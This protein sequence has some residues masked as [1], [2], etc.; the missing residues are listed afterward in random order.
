MNEK[1]LFINISTRFQS[2]N[3]KAW[4]E[5]TLL[6][7]SLY[8]YLIVKEKMGGKLRWCVMMWWWRLF[9]T[10]SKCWYNLLFVISKIKRGS[11]WNS[12]FGWIKQWMSEN[13]V[14]VTHKKMFFKKIHYNYIHGLSLVFR[15]INQRILLASIVY[16]K[17]RTS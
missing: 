11:Y 15:L 10:L 13:V 16:N 14:P 4:G 2:Q 3:V 9:I 1:F 17:S 12:L 7:E 5:E 8:H 6:L